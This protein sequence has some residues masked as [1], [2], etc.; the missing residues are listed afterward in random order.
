MNYSVMNFVSSRLR[1]SSRTAIP[2]AISNVPELARTKIFEPVL[3]PV[4][5]R[6]LP[7]VVGAVG[8]N[9][10]EAVTEVDTDAEADALLD[11]DAEVLCDGDGEVLFDTDGDGEALFDGD[12]EG[13]VGHCFVTVYCSHHVYGS[14]A[15]AGATETSA[16]N[17]LTA[18]TA[19]TFFM[20]LPWVVWFRR[21]CSEAESNGLSLL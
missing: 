21:A 6:L 2:A 13:H 5:G 7:V 12:A 3:E 20:L 10:V 19:S 15:S 14:V 9:V 17:R 4:T 16:T 18:S 8:L 11:G 1:R